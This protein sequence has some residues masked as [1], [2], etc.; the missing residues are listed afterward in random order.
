M[1][2]NYILPILLGV[3]GVAFV[4]SYMKKK[5]SKGGEKPFKI[6]VPEPE[7]I[8]EAQF[9]V[10]SD[11]F[12][13]GKG[14]KGYNVKLL[15]QALGGKDKLPNSF[16]KGT[17]DGIFGSETESV[18]QAQTGKTTVASMSELESIASKNGLVKSL[19]PFGYTFIPKAKQNILTKGSKGLPLFKG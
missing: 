1:K 12:P 2:K 7:K 10:G 15:Q 14:A 16:K 11:K 9:N 5:K 3:A 8:D 4:Y 6:D 19:T 18:L 17:P 13:M